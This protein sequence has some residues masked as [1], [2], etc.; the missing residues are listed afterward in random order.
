MLA[1]RLLEVAAAGERDPA[2]LRSEALS[3]VVTSRV[4]RSR[5][6]CVWIPGSMLISSFRGARAPSRLLPTWPQTCRSRVNPRSDGEPGIHNPQRYGVW[7]PGPPGFA[8][9]AEFIIGPA[10][11]RTRWPA[12]PE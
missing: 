6:A 10:F 9:R 4:V 11:G 1:M 7:I 12:V 8:L 5:V 2:R 3:T